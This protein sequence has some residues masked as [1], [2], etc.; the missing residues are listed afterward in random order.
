MPASVSSIRR[1]IRSVWILSIS[2]SQALHA[3]L[4]RDADPRSAGAVLRFRVRRYRGQLQSVGSEKRG[5]RCASSPKCARWKSRD[6]LIIL[7]RALDRV[8]RSTHSWIPNWHSANHRV[9]YWDMFGFPETLSRTM[10]FPVEST[11]WFDAEKAKCHRQGLTNRS[12]EQRSAWAPI[13]HDA[14][15]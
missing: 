1:S 4:R 11:W 3:I 14:F 9:A 15:C 8:L 13:S 2:T 12:E 5:C 7:L 10:P 6:E